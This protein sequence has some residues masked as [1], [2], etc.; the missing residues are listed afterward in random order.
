MMWSLHPGRFSILSD[1]PSAPQTLTRKEFE[2]MPFVGQDIYRA[3][4]RL[5]GVTASDFFCA[6]YGA[7]W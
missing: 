1:A 3:V 6:L 5:P 7:W 4:A 2:A